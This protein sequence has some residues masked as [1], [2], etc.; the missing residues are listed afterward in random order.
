M[1][2]NPNGDSIILTYASC[3]RCQWHDDLKA[4]NAGN[5]SIISADLLQNIG[6]EINAKRQEEIAK[7]QE[8]LLQRVSDS[9]PPHALEVHPLTCLLSHCLVHT[10][11]A[12]CFTLHTSHFTLHASCFMLHAS[13]FMLHVPITSC[14]HCSNSMLHSS[15][16]HVETAS[17]STWQ[18]AC[19]RP[20]TA[21][22]QSF[23]APSP[24][25]TSTTPCCSQHTRDT[26]RGSRQPRSACSVCL[27]CHAHLIHK[28]E[29]DTLWDGSESFCRHASDG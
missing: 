17:T 2:E 8:E 27:G 9:H 23:W 5:I 21:L 28:C 15:L 10:Y 20:E 13:R 14:N 24:S 22:P 1:C 7:R 26:S 16:Q 12:S 11:A 29:S 19:Y 25:Q 18:P 3:V 6:F 4:N